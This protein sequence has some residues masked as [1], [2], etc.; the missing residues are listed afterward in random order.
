MESEGGP[1]VG[2]VKGYASQQQLDGQGARLAALDDGLHNVGGQIGK[3]QK[4]ADVGTA[5]PKALRNLG[6]IDEFTLLQPAKQNAL[7]R[8]VSFGGLP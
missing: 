8:Q 1:L 7:I 4:P 6:G 2:P 3:P 5:E